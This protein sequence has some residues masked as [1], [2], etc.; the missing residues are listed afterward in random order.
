MTAIL[1]GLALATGAGFAY[2][3]GAG[4]GGGGGHGGGHSA[5]GFRGGGQAFAGGGM[6]G[7]PVASGG[8]TRFTTGP[9][10]S[11]PIAG[12]RPGPIVGRPGFP[13]R[14]V[15]V[16]GGA[17]IVA[18]PYYYWYP[19]YPYSYPYPYVAPAYGGSAYEDTPQYIEQGS[20]QIRYY[21][22]DY[23]DY[24]PNVQNCPSPWMQVIPDTGAYPN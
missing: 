23:Q 14:R 18:A 24:Y 8:F 21:C 6:V 13:P 22:P 20:S 1:L 9:H 16:G 11:H 7:R 3:R 15:I 4:G 10:P 17:V 2:A 19:P 12:V 5:G